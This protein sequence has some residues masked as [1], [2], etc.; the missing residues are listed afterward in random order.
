M[1]AQFRTNV[2]IKD[3]DR[4]KLSPALSYILERSVMSTSGKNFGVTLQ[5]VAGSGVNM[6]LQGEVFHAYVENDHSL[7][8]SLEQRHSL[9]TSLTVAYA[10]SF[11]SC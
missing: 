5:T 3:D 8:G 4:L 7:W 9:K 6:S 1:N 10:G 2:T 11:L